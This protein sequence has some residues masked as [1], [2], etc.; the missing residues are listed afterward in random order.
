MLSDQPFHWA[1]LACLVERWSSIS[2]PFSEHNSC[3]YGSFK[4]YLY[5]A[6]SG[7]LSCGITHTA[8]VP[9]VSGTAMEIGL[10]S[11]GG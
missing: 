9:L 4:Y 11:I 6:I 3:E 5:C 1:R 2:F 7:M 10:V 8:V